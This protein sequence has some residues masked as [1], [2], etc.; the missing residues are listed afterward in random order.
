MRPRPMKSIKGTM[1]WRVAFILSSCKTSPRLLRRHPIWPTEVKLNEER[2]PE[3]ISWRVTL[4][5]FEITEDM[6]EN[7][8]ISAFR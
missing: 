3:R 1:T 6:T 5:F 7:P 2:F 8:S 4:R